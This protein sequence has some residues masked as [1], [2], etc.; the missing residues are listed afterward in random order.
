MHNDVET[1]CRIKLLFNC[2]IL[3]VAINTKLIN[4]KTMS[5]LGAIE[6][7]PYH[8]GKGVTHSPVTSL[9]EGFNFNPV[10]NYTCV[11]DNVFNYDVGEMVSIT[12]YH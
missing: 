2:L 12:L 3:S 8:F 6:I 5:D 11:A 9:V 1:W 7:H 4:V 10:W